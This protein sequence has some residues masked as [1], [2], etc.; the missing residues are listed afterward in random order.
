M[1]DPVLLFFLFYPVLGRIFTPAEF[2]LLAVI[3]SIVSVL[4]VVGSGRYEGGILVADDKKEAAHLAALSL[5]VGFV[6][7]AVLWPVV[8]IFFGEQLAHPGGGKLALHAGLVL[9]GHGNAHLAYLP[10]DRVEGHLFGDG[11]RVDGVVRVQLR[12]LLRDHVEQQQVHVRR[13][14]LVVKTEGVGI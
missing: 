4:A 12:T 9:A 13:H 5:L 3:T 10:L 11:Q 2:G 8:Q 6:C 1:P 14:L 7:M